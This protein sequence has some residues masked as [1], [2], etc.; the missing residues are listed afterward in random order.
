M[1]APPT[2]ANVTTSQTVFDSGLR[3][4]LSVTSPNSVTDGNQRK[5]LPINACDVVTASE[6]GA[7][8]MGLQVMLSEM[9][10][11]LDGVA[12][13]GYQMP[14]SG[15]DLRQLYDAIVELH[16]LEVATADATARYWLQASCAAIEQLPALAYPGKRGAA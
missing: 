13:T 5:S 6:V 3:Q 2:A 16:G 10:D 11:D 1:M 14:Y 7:P 15:H 12:A 8:P 4:N 9:A